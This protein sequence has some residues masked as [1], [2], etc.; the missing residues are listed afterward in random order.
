M[1]LIV[2]SAAVLL[3][4]LLTLAAFLVVRTLTYQSPAADHTE[5]D[6]VSAPTVNIEQAAAHLSEAIRFRTITEQDDGAADMSQWDAMHEWLART[7]PLVHANLRLEKVAGHTLIFTFEGSD[8][9]LEPF[10][11]MAHQDV[12]PVVESTVS[13][14]KHPP[15]DGVIADGAV[16][17]RGSVDD[18]GSMIAILESV[19]SLLQS[20]FKPKR[21][22]IIVNGHDEEGP[23]E[24]ATAAAAWFRDKGIKAEFVLDEGL[25]TITDFPLLKDRV[26]LVGIAEKG[27]ATLQL[28]ATGP[29]GHSSMPPEDTAVA[30][31]AQAIL[32]VAN[33]PDPMDITGPG[34]E[35]LRVVAPY[36][37]FLTRMAIANEW[38]FKPLLIDQVAATP[39]GAAL[40]HTTMAPTMLRASPKEN[41]LPNSASAIINYRI[42]PG[43]TTAD[44]VERAQTGI[45]DLPVS[46]KLG[47]EAQDPSPISSTTSEP[48]MIIA[49]LASQKNSIPVAP[50]LVLAAT[51]SYQL[52]TVAND[53]YRFQPIELSLSETSMI[54]GINENMTLDN[55]KRMI[56]FYGSLIATAG[57]R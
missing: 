7:Y 45:G 34:A 10:V 13:Q 39:A 4:L 49:A 12:V 47:K 43:E 25:V 50:G 20:G 21:T 54:H 48:W 29:G 9:S 57:S 22:L 40:L 19:E 28:T 30:T 56:D 15:F 8:K 18:K 5:I 52:T 32:A 17:G 3:G 14:W 24:G 37:P 1:K 51:D 53:V 16:W 33:N 26:A 31:L 2:R 42:I 38:L 6:L 55:L 41:V 27:Y 11:L 35:T 44:V 36:A 46:I 23:H